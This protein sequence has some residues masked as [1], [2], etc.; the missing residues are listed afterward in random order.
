MSQVSEANFKEKINELKKSTVDIADQLKTNLDIVKKTV[1]EAVDEAHKEEQFA[2]KSTAHKEKSKEKKLMKD[3]TKT[4]KGK[5]PAQKK[6]II[7]T[8]EKKVKVIKKIAKA[9]AVKK[10]E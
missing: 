8:A 4:A 6:K 7:K 9:K 1:G 2:S 10:T 5:S 3:A